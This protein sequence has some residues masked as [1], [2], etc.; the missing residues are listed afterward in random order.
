MVV[1]SQT[2]AGAR[3]EHAT[4]KERGADQDI[5]DVE[6]GISPLSATMPPH[7]A[8]MLCCTQR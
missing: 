8:R 2:I 3:V 5:D 6:H 7:A 1:A 4:A